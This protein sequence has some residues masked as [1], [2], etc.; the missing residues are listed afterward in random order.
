MTH[1]GRQKYVK[2][3]EEGKKNRREIGVLKCRWSLSRR[4]RR[5]RLQ[6]N[7]N[8]DF[9]MIQFDSPSIREEPVGAWEKTLEFYQDL[10]V[11]AGVF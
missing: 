1:L 9:F 4:R 2:L 10:L 5:R 3:C 6:V 8:C 11:S 7:R